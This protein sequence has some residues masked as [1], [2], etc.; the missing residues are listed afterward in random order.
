MRL[1]IV[2][3]PAVPAACLP[4]HAAGCAAAAAAGKEAT[5]RGKERACGARGSPSVGTLF[6]KEKN[7]LCSSTGPKCNNMY[8]LYCVLVVNHVSFV[9]PLVKSTPR[10]SKRDLSASCRCNSA[11][12]A[13]H[14]LFPC[15]QTQ[16]C[17]SILSILRHASCLHAVSGR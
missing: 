10:L 9:L 4:L 15:L 8:F 5:E 14:I 1:R 17:F 7:I 16:F 6:R 12:S 11:T 3:H 2:C 13:F